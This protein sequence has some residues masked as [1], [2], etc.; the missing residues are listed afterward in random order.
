M[1]SW[2][3]VQKDVFNN[4]YEFPV[5]NWWEKITWYYNKFNFEKNKTLI[6]TRWSA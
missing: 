5:Y 3:F 4:N 1:S 2:K 6:I